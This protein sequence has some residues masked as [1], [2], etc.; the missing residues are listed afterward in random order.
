MC[1]QFQAK[2]ILLDCILLH[3]EYVPVS[4]GGNIL[5]KRQQERQRKAEDV[6]KQQ[7][8]PAEKSPEKPADKLQ[9]KSP[10]KAKPPEESAVV[11]T[12]RSLIGFLFDP[13]KWTGPAKEELPKSVYAEAQEPRSVYVRKALSPS[14]ASSSEEK[15]AS[16]EK[17]ASVE[18]KTEPKSE[19]EKRGDKV[20]SKSEYEK[21]AQKVESKSEYEKKGEKVEPK[22]EAEKRSDEKVGEKD[23][24]E[25]K[26][27]FAEKRWKYRS[28]MKKTPANTAWVQGS[29]ER[30][31]L[32]LNRA[33]LR[34]KRPKKKN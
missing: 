28:A 5:A 3:P 16:K 4:W 15:K 2:R 27:A 8:K 31:Q 23:A 29:P 9:E 7:E 30:R 19:A 6:K 22:S 11:R 1:F 34:L 33:K 12:T 24:Q 18:L 20:E 21:K 32:Q 17:G 13:K 14:P 10:E 26:R 25:V